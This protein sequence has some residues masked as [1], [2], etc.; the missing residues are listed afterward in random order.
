M[1]AEI[2]QKL[3]L[4]PSGRLEW[5]M[6]GNTLHVVPVKEDTIAAFRGQGKEDSVARLLAERS[7]D[8]AHK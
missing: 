4:S 2:R 5:F 7:K 1:P 3:H 6:Y 8:N